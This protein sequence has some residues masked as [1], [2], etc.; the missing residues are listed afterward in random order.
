LRRS[1]TTGHSAIDSGNFAQHGEGVIAGAVIHQHDLKALAGRLHHHL[2]AVIKIGDIFLL[3]V[4]WDD[5]GV[6]G[7]SLFIIAGC[8]LSAR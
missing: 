5:D 7:H 6:P 1:F 3:V 2:Q 8:I 4:K